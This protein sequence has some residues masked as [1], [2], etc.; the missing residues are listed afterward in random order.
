MNGQ[1]RPAHHGRPRPNHVGEICSTVRI[2]W[3]SLS[4]ML[5]TIQ[6]KVPVKHE[7]FPERKNSSFFFHKFKIWRLVISW[8]SDPWWTHDF[9][10]EINLSHLW[11]T[12]Y[13][14][15]ITYNRSYIIYVYIYMLHTFGIC[16]LLNI[17][18]T[19]WYPFAMN[20]FQLK[21][22]GPMRCAP[23]GPKT[24]WFPFNER[25]GHINSTCWTHRDQTCL[26]GGF[27][28]SE[29]YYCSQME[30]LS[31]IGVKIKK[32]ETTTQLSILS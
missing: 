11:Q 31:Q 19:P 12:I 27:N 28:P 1:L 8:V 10:R 13:L 20:R 6:V 22:S 16:T 7:N 18:F 29:K 15:Q 14:L 17:R 24:S 26:V 3:T 5:S 4:H 23:N 32:I 30:N 21:A 2:P 9:L 25:Y